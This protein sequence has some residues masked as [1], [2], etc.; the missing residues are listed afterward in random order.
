MGGYLSAVS[1]DDLLPFP[2]FSNFYKIFFV[3]M[4]PLKFPNATFLT[5]TIQF[6]PNFMTNMLVMENM[7]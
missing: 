5:V 7:G 3:N 4:G 6:R 2:K 1:P